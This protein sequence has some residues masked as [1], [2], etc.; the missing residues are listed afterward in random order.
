M[1][2]ES[3]R[4][5]SCPCLLKFDNTRYDTVFM[6][7]YLVYQAFSYSV[8]SLALR[9]HTQY[10]HYISE[11][12]FAAPQNVMLS[13]RL[14]LPRN[15]AIPKKPL[16]LT[17]RSHTA[18]DTTLK[19]QPMPR[20][21]TLTFI[22]VA[23]PFARL[24]CPVRQIIVNLEQLKLEY[25]QRIYPEI[26]DLGLIRRQEDDIGCS[27]TVMLRLI[28]PQVRAMSSGLAR[29]KIAC[30]WLIDSRSPKLVTSIYE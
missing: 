26:A 14:F 9:F 20:R 3:V 15:P 5:Q 19:S 28:R 27:K 11:Q 30:D 18:R 10:Y 25:V 7:H 17:D 12:G 8:D 21:S 4:P 23:S 29:D 13:I 6:Y 24:H 1:E 22:G 2:P 16:D